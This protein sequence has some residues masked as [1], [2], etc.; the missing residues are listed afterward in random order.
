MYTYQVEYHKK[1]AIPFACI[2]FVIVGAPLAVRFPRGGVG[3]VIAV[4]LLIFGIY[5]IS[6]I[7]GESLGDRGKVSPFWG[8]WAPNFLFLLVAIWGVARIGR[9]TSTARGGG[10]LDWWIAFRE[11]LG[12][13]RRRSA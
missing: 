11:Y 8:P 6:L 10:W 4:S 12:R 1:F 13:P 2:V 5:Y 9:E 7:G 3:M